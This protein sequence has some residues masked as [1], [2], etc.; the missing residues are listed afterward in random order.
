MP[1]APEVQAIDA[2]VHGMSRHQ[3]SYWLHEDRGVRRVLRALS[4]V[5]RQEGRGQIL[6]RSFRAR[7]AEGTRATEQATASRDGQCLRLVRAAVGDSLASRLS[8]AMQGHWTLDAA[9][10]SS[11]IAGWPEAAEFVVRI[12][13]GRGV[14][15]GI[16][17]K[18]RAIH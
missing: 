18:T 5:S 4:G 12:C 17:W 14:R 15:R 10:T 7:E 6:G 1:G 2:D 9:V 11:S 8:R 13:L 16:P 3:T